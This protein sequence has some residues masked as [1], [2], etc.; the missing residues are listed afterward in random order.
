MFGSRSFRLSRAVI[1]SALGLV[2]VPIHAAAQVSVS[3]SPSGGTYSNSNL[4]VTMD[5]CSTASPILTY[6]VYFNGQDAS[7]SFS[8]QG[9]VPGCTGGQRYTGTLALEP[10]SNS[11]TADAWDEGD[12]W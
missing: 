10:G 1:G 3:F 7:G 8:Y 6:M 12:N 11:L 9:G 2:L 5:L 4:S